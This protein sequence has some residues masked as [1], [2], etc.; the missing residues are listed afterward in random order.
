MWAP[1]ADRWRPG[2]LWLAVLVSNIGL[3]M[4]TLGAQAWPC[5]SGSLTP[6]CWW[7][8]CRPRTCSPTPSSGWW[9]GCSPDTLDRRHLLMAVQTF[10][11]AT[12]VVLTVLTSVGQMPP[13]LLLIFTFLLVGCMSR[14]CLPIN[15]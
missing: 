3:W 15:R 12:G 9:A 11:V 4:Q 2:V 6:P 13:A 14:G 1:S 10:M 7:P 8:W 5:W